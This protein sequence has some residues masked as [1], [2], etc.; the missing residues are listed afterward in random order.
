MQT[1]KRARDL[2]YVVPIV[3][4]C[5]GYAYE[6]HFKRKKVNVQ[7]YSSQWNCL[8]QDSFSNTLTQSS[9]CYNIHVVTKQVLKIHKE[10]T[11]IE[12]ATSRFQ[13]YKYIDVAFR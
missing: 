6:G 11:E 2:S 13:V 4:A 1:G 5:P 3:P 9:F 7:I 8:S 12:E 10:S